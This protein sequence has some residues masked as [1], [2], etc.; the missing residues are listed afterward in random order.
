MKRLRRLLDIL[1]ALALL[2]GLAFAALMVRNYL[3]PPE[4]ISAAP[5]DV[6]IIDGDSLRVGGRIVRLQ[7]IDAPEHRQSCRDGA[8]A[9]WPCGREASAALARLAQT[10]RLTC[11]SHGQDQYR[12]AVARC[13]N[14][15]GTDLARAL[16]NDGWAVVLPRYALPGYEQAE[17]SARETG[18]GI[19]RGE[20]DHPAD[21]RAAHGTGRDSE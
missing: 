10:S 18:R 2:A 21:W 3:Y 4:L 19:W 8:G 17:E 14:A 1:A 5:G 9:E 16:L 20:F 6:H 13:R 11:E 7:G 15:A 12:R